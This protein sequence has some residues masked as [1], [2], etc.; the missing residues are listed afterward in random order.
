MGWN[1]GGISSGGSLVERRRSSELN[2]CERVGQV[3]SPSRANLEL[4]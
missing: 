4:A 2:E 1:E 3:I